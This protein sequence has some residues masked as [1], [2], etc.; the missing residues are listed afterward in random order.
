MLAL[1]SQRKLQR[2]WDLRWKSWSLV[3]KE[4]GSHLHPSWQAIEE[5][6]C[7][8][9][10]R[11]TAVRGLVGRS[12]WSYCLSS[13]GV[14]NVRNWLWVRGSKNRGLETKTKPDGVTTLHILDN[15]T[16]RVT[17]YHSLAEL[18][19]FINK[20]LR[21]F[22]ATGISGV[23]VHISGSPWPLSQSSLPK[24]KFFPPIKGHHLD[25]LQ[26]RFHTTFSS[27]ECFCINLA[28]LLHFYYKHATF[29]ISDYQQLK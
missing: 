24:E 11:S 23:C 19:Y 25:T 9:W 28:S 20:L 12:R 15:Q 5:A 21:T 4:P 2:V 7:R 3:R 13:H 16:E 17:T 14:E 27:L 10:A 22:S 18:S 26:V 29:I 8:V 6:E 1:T